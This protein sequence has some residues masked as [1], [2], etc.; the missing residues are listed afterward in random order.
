M[1]CPA[2]FSIWYLFDNR[3][4]RNSFIYDQ[5]NFAADDKNYS[6]TNHNHVMPHA[7]IPNFRHWDWT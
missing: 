3:R 6:F 1:Q 4:V 2:I 7:T 5:Q